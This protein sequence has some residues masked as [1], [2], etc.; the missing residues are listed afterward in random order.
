MRMPSVSWSRFGP[1][2]DSRCFPPAMERVLQALNCAA[3]PTICSWTQSAGAFTS[4]AGRASSTCLMREIATIV[5]SP[6]CPPCEERAL[7]TTFR[8]W[9][10]CFSRCVRHRWSRPPCGYTVRCREWASKEW[11]TNEASDFEDRVFFIAYV[12]S[13]YRRS[14]G[15]LDGVIRVSAVRRYRCGGGRSAGGGNRVGAGRSTTRERADVADRAVHDLQ[16]WLRKK[17]GIRVSG[18]GTIPA[19]EF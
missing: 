7:P 15:W 6:E 9:T 17:L 19:G 3:M 8:R 14:H 16:L 10:G 4:V 11:R 1:R 13:G 18:P 2:E 12:R 5:A